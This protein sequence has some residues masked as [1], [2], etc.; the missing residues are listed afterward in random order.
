MNHPVN[1][2]CLGRWGANHLGHDDF[3]DWQ[4]TATLDV[5]NITGLCRECKLILRN[6][7]ATG[8]AADPRDFVT[9]EQ[10]AANIAQALTP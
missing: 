7:R 6:E 3:V 1:R 5:H 10:A 8:V 9:P 2:Q 4:C